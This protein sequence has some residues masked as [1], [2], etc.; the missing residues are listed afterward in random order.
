[1]AGSTLEVY[2]TDRLGSV[3]AITA[4]AGVV[5]ATYR[6]DEFGVPTATTGSSTQPFPARGRPR[7]N[8]ALARPTGD[9]RA[10][11]TYTIPIEGPDQ[12]LAAARRL[13]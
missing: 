3:H 1:M 8:M 10:L 12:W 6:T 9:G 13:A 4:A 2:Q 5:T 11:A 7:K